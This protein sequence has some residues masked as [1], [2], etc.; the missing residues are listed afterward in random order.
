MPCSRMRGGTCIKKITETWPGK[1]DT[2]WQILPNHKEDHD[3]PADD[4]DHDDSSDGEVQHD[5][6]KPYGRA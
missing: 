5:G 2:D 4:S 1:A 6:D 3:V